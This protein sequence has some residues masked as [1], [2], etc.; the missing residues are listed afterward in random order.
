[1]FAKRDRVMQTSLLNVFVR[2]SQKTLDKSRNYGSSSSSLSETEKCPLS[3]ATFAALLKE[4][5]SFSVEFVQ[6]GLADNAPGKP[7]DQMKAE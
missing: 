2:L 4:I 5:D 6:K 3:D 7:I 1:M